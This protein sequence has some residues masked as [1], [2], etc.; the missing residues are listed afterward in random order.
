MRGRFPLIRIALGFPPRDPPS[1][2]RGEGSE[3]AL[4][5]C[6]YRFDCQT[7]RLRFRYGAASQAPSPLFFAAPA[8][9]LRASARQPAHCPRFARGRAIAPLFLAARGAPYSVP[10]LSPRRRGLRRAFLFPAAQGPGES[11]PD[12]MPRGRSAAWRPSW[13]RRANKCTQFA[14][15]ICAS[16]RGHPWRRV[17]APRRSI[18][19][20]FVPG[21]VASGRDKRGRP[22]G[23]PLPGRLPPPFV[24]AA[25]SHSRQSLLVGTDGWPGPPDP[26]VT[27]RSSGRR[28]LLHRRDVSRRR[29]QPS[30]A[31][32]SVQADCGGN[33]DYIPSIF[34]WPN[35]LFTLP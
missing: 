10:A 20:I 23:L 21:A 34:R 2:T 17:R 22:C 26:A 12:K 33:M 7:A 3:R 27:S 31:G 35:M 1:P 28:A 32:R 9:A 6:L 15:L 19:A 25:S 29:P 8:F 18:A 14:P 30:Q 24:P 5:S 13:P 11:T 4:R 16:K